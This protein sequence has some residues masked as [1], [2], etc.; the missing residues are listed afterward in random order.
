MK[1][2]ILVFA[3]S[4]SRSVME[5]LDRHFL[6]HHVYRQPAAEQ[7]AYID[8]VA[9]NVRGIMT[10]GPIGVS[11]A[12]AAR[13]PRLE[14]VALNSVGYDK[15]DFEALRP[16][17]VLV[18]NTPDVLTDDVADL[19]VLLVLASA[20]RL[21]AMDRFV[22]NGD[23]AARKPLVPARSVRGKV[24]GIFGFGRIGQAIGARLAALGM[25]IRYHQPRAIAGVAAPRADSLLDLARQS[26]YLILAAPA[27]AATFRAV[28]AAVMDA[29]GPEGT[30]VN[31]AR[32]SLVDEEALVSALQTGRLG[33]AALDVFDLEPQVPAALR[34][35]ENVVLTPH[36]GSLTAETRHAMGQLTVDNL[37][38]HF[39]GRPLPTPVH[40]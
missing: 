1:P 27:N 26:D 13:L 29:L 12:L 3:A 6:C 16:R 23:W 39:E 22:R 19:T 24:A 36:I 30:L 21:P 18:T 8:G 20:R 2:E 34:A 37:L 31:I 11:A 32:G 7:D 9:P 17:G 35:L 33:A 25:E 14:I 28:D 38:A 10:V 40:S 4:P 15:I 5:Q